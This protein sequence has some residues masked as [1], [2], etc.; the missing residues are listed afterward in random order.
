M[1]SIHDRLRV[2]VRESARSA[3]K[4]I[5]D[6]HPDETFYGFALYT[7]DCASFLYPAANSIEGLERRV[8]KYHEDGHGETTADDLRWNPAD[9][10]YPEIGDGHFDAVEEVFGELPD[11]YEL[12]DDDEVE[13]EAKRR[14]DAIVAGFRGL[15]KEGF[16]GKG[17]ARNKIA[18]MIM[19]DIEGELIE[20]WLK[21]LNPPKVLEQFADWFAEDPVGD[22]VEIGS[23]NVRDVR[24]VAIARAGTVL[25]AAGDYHIFVFDAATLTETMKKRVG[26]YKG[27]HWSIS[28]MAISP[29]GSE[30]ALTWKSGFNDDTGIE[31]WS[32]PKQK[33]LPAP[34][35]LQGRLATIDYSPDGSRI[36]SGG[37]AGVLRVWDVK[38]CEVVLDVPGYA[39]LIEKVRFSPDGMTF[40]SLSMKR[41]GLCVWDA[42]TG[43]L[44][45]A[46]G[47]TGCGM[48]FSPD[49]SLLAVVSG[50]NDKNA[51]HDVRIWDVQTGK[52][53]TR[54]TGLSH[55]TDPVA[56]SLDGC[57][58]ATG[59]ALDGFVELWDWEQ[60]KQLSRLDP[61]YAWV[62][63]LAFLADDE[64][65]AVVGEGDGK[66]R[67][68]VLIWNLSELLNR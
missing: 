63:D 53:R 68:P 35:I 48:A 17:S 3:F 6:K 56:F 33:R 5:Q 11:I 60:N 55:R 31:R 44:R 58:L 67:P 43:K 40:A 16:F 13:R 51:E 7:N 12:D 19:G 27:A 54:V 8:R 29:D 20:D 65:V 45:T 62:N 42:E 25:A 30:L 47:D 9:W 39:D 50:D 32:I 38:S 24:A 61:K 59:T 52:L 18:L 4:A 2:A 64:H 15:H 37:E 14:F 23:R 22:F 36:L 10:F 28:G 26:S 57:L 46:I 66:A 34:E 21:Q 1:P 49:G 41:P